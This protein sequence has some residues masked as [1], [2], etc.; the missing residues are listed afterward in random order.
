MY[1]SDK[2][3]SD[4]AKGKCKSRKIMLREASV[5]YLTKPK[6]SRLLGNAKIRV[7]FRS[8]F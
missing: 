8:R 2:D 7:S 6:K 1:D 4:V 5:K 3:L